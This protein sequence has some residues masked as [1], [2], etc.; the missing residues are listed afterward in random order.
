M[1]I[2][3]ERSGR[4][5][6]IAPPN[7]LD[8]NHVQ[9]IS[10][11]PPEVSCLIQGG[12]S[13]RPI[14][15]PQSLS[16]GWSESIQSV[17]EQP[18]ASFS[19]YL[20]L[21]GLAFIGF[22]GV[23]ASVGRMQEV[24]QASGELV[25]QGET[26]KI[27]PTIAGEVDQIL[28]EEGDYVRKGDL[29]L[30]LDS[31]LLESEVVRLTQTLSAAQTE[32][33]QGRSLIEK[34]RSESI[35]QQQIAEANIQAQI[36]TWEQSQASTQTSQALLRSLDS[37][38]AAHEERLDRLSTLETAGAISKEYLFEVE[39]GVRDQQKATRQTQG[40]LAEGLA[41]TR[42]MEAELAQKRAQAQQTALS[43]EQSLQQ[44]RMEAE[45]LQATIADTQALIEEAN[46]RLA[47]T[48][49]RSPSNGTVSALEIDHI[50]EFVQPGAMLAEIVPAA[51]PLVVSATVPPSEAGLIKT[52]MDTKIK[53]DAFPYQNYGVLTG[54]IIAI[55]PDAKGTPET[56]RGYQVD[57]ALD[58]DYV[59]H[60]G[61]P[62]KLQLG[63]TARIEIV[64]RQR[65]IID[66]ILDPIRRLSADDL[67]L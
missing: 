38:T 3:T 17:L 43:A 37:E 11:L 16:D 57:V 66:L 35:A 34:T 51:T 21:L 63:Q 58:K 12:V 9:A 67:S 7:S 26:Y 61:K 52:G 60:Q 53:L 50:G 4:D 49:V 32:L 23:W 54:T 31:A 28:V 36:A 39:Q 15:T 44:M 65:R 47:Q 64:I 10:D 18:P 56:T 30:Q 25:P 22:F 5:R 20:I 62:V 45:A 33:D 19:L 13:S 46:V 42:Q 29:L 8:K 2:T 1:N 41:Q 40:E 14:E 24:S 59:M 6:A 55:S 48:Q 27:Q